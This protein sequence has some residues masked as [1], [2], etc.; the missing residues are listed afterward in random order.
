ML[1]KIDL[2]SDEPIYRQIERQVIEGI[3]YGRLKYGEK[4][5][6][7]R[8]LAAELGINLHTVN[9]AYLVLKNEGFISI[10]RQKGVVINRKRSVPGLELD[11]YIDRLKDE[12]KPLIMEAYCRGIE[13]E[14]VKSA[15]DEIYKDLQKGGSDL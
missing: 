3:A 6:S 8:R 14:N 10:L 13:L 12:L 1:M 4:L 11:K 15:C 2:E 5:P 9:K 7:V